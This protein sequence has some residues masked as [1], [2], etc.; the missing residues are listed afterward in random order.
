MRHARPRLVLVDDH[1]L[2]ADTLRTSLQAQF[3]VL[4]IARSGG[5]LLCMLK[6]MQPDCLLLDLSLPG[7][8]GLELL[9]D[10][11]ALRPQLRIVI[12]TM[13]VEEGLAEAAL[14]AGAHG[15][16]PKDAGLEELK[17]AINE[18][19][20]GRRYVSP[21]VRHQPSRVGGGQALGL[22]RLTPRQQEIVRLIGDGKST[23]Q[24]A[25]EL[26]LSESTVSL[27]RHNIRKA[28]GMHTEWEFARYAILVQLGE[29][30]HVAM[31]SGQPVPL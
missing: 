26:D 6:T 15:F 27:H 31:K 24:I 17:V 3:T 16:V 11:T 12:V 20:A 8:N 21:A 18:V 13:H 25:D 29:D 10:I 1:Q 7:R 30:E 23:S 9:P 28:L 19:L 22:C 4:G 5:E 2:L 14:Q